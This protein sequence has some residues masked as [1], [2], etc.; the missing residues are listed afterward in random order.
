MFRSFFGLTNQDASE[1]FSVHVLKK[2]V[3]ANC[4]MQPLFLYINVMLMDASFKFSKQLSMLI[5]DTR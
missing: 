4:K 3:L 5:K 1:I 2:G